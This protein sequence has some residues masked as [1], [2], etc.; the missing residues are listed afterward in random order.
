MSTTWYYCRAVF[1]CTSSQPTAA[2]LAAASENRRWHRLHRHVPVPQPHCKNDRHLLCVG[3]PHARVRDYTS[4]PCG[5]RG[6]WPSMRRTASPTEQTAAALS[7]ISNS[8]AA[9]SRY[10]RYS[11]YGVPPIRWSLTGNGKPLSSHPPR[12]TGRGGTMPFEPWLS[13]KAIAKTYTHILA[14]LSCGCN[15]ST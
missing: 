3:A 13:C 6:I 15:F 11:R 10:S 7:Q 5:P 4:T 8:R 12:V 14:A 2:A 1:E 9:Y